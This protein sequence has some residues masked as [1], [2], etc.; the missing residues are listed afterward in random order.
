MWESISLSKNNPRLAA[1]HYVEKQTPFTVCVC[2]RIMH[3]NVEDEDEDDDDDDDDDGKIAKS[4]N[5]Q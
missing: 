4:S 2:V 1:K 5:S 3:D